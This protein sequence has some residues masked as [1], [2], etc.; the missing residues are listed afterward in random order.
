MV[1]MPSSLST[2]MNL[3]DMNGSLGC[4]LL[5]KGSDGVRIEPD[6]ACHQVYEICKLAQA[7]QKAAT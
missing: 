1:G 5:V 3:A 4:R 2:V 6:R 7:K